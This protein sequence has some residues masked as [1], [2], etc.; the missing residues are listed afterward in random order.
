MTQE[1]RSINECESFLRLEQLAKNPLDLTERGV[2][3]PERIQKYCC[4]GESFDLLY[5]CQRVT[6]EVV[7]T[8]QALADECALVKQFADMRQG[9]VMNCIH[10][11]PSEKRQVLHT[12]CRDI[13]TKNPAN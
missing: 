1:W 10:G 4:T 5:S 6:D 13:F 3:T 8:L 9:A 11:Y 7:V 12:A 2:L